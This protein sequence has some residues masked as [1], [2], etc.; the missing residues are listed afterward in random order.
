VADFIGRSLP[1]LSG[2]GMAQSVMMKE[3]VS[4]ET[5]AF[6]AVVAS[7]PGYPADSGPGVATSPD[8]SGKTSVSARDE[9]YATDRILVKFKPGISERVRQ[10]IHRAQGASVVGELKGIGVQI[11]K[12]PNSK[13]MEKV[14][15]YRAHGSVEYAEP[16][17]IATAYEVPNDPSFNQQWGMTQIDAPEAW[18]ATTGSSSGKIAILDTGIDIHHPDLDGKMLR[19]TCT[20]IPTV[21]LRMTFM[22]TARMLPASPLPKRTTMSV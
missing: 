21:P 9:S 5:L 12:V 1:T 2:T 3:C 13:V 19:V 6:A 15:A 16:D 22:V 17:Y 7:D 11:L 10:D 18:S 20:I 4:N 14:L 8:Q